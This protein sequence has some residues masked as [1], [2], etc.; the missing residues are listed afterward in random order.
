MT[1]R[2]LRPGNPAAAAFASVLAVAVLMPGC[3][4]GVAKAV[5]RPDRGL[6]ALGTAV[7]DFVLQNQDSRPI[8]LRD[9]RGTVVVVT[10]LY[11]RCPLPDYC[12][13]LMTSLGRVRR[14][15]AEDA[16]VWRQVRLIGVSFDPAH[17]TPERLRAYGAA[18]AGDGEPFDHFDLATG[19]PSAVEQLAASLGLTYRQ[20]SGQVVHTLATALIDR[21]G[22]LA[23]VIAGS[24]WNPAQLAAT[25]K[26]LVLLPRTG[27]PSTLERNHD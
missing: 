3:R 27:G 7:P 12:P 25:I 16:A 2:L 5:D 19:D 13:L 26:G 22:R 4:S 17:D 11:T 9:L 15:L 18:F 23:N 6:L 8:R 10:F 20:E 1:W 21:D 24:D 14:A